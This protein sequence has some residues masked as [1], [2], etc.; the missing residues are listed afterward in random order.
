VSK[1]DSLRK[2]TV[3]AEKDF[4]NEIVEYNGDKFEIR[5]PSVS[6]RSKILKKASVS[7]D[8]DDFGKVE[9]DKMQIYA[10]IYCTY[11]PDTDE[12]VFDESDIP[13]LKD[14]PTDSFVDDFAAAAM[15]LMNAKPQEDA[16]N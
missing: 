6:V 15:S 5:Q 11:V 3:G 4:A 14:Q 16:K 10:V 2:L 13:A 7:D 9:F 1:R 12:R 8:F